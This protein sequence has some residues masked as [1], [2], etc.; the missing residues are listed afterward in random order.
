M[1]RFA[2]IDPVNAGNAQSGSIPRGALRNGSRPLE[3][4][5]LIGDCRTAALVGR[6]GSIDWLCCPR[7][8]S[9]ACFAALLGDSSNG[10]WSIAPCDR[11]ARVSRCYRDGTLVLETGFTA[12]SGRA[13]IIDFMVPHGRGSKIVRLVRGDAG[14]LDM[15]MEL[16]LRFGYGAT[17]PWVSRAPD[18]TLRAVAGPDMMVLRTPVALHGEDL[19]THA[20]FTVRAG[21]TIPF[22]LTYGPSHL[23]EPPT[24]DPDEALRICE[25]FWRDWVD[26]ADA[27]GPYRDIVL[28]SLITLKALTYAPSGGIVAAPTASLPERLGGERNWDYRYCWIRDSTFTLLALMDAGVL[29]EARAWRD[30]LKRAVAGAPAD[31]Q[32]M[33]GLMGER[34]LTEWEA[35]WLRGYAGSRPVRIGNAAHRQ[36]QL[37][38]YGELMDTFEQARKT[39]LTTTDD[40]WAVQVALVKHVAARWRDPDYGMWETRGVPRHF[41]FSKVMAWVTFDRAIQAI[42]LHG[43]SGPIEEW[44]AIRAEIH[45][46]VCRR[47]FDIHANTFRAAYDTT[48]LDASLLLLAQVG[49]LAP[50]DPRFVGTVEAIERH[51]LVDG[52]VL[53]YDTAR[54]PDGLEPGEGVFLACS[55]WLA[56]AYLSLG[57]EA[58]AKAMFERLLGLCNDVG[59][60][61]EEYEPGLRRQVGNFPQ[62]FSHVALINT[63]F[64][65]THA[66][67]PAEQ[68]AK[69]ATPPAK[70]T[71]EAA[72]G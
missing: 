45:R 66:E 55:F 54:E 22:V 26:K 56:D 19:R 21:Q 52:L 12:A 48:T 40:G 14:S 3:E 67:R 8:D 29:E 25:S 11:S 24:I 49:F 38:V 50:D 15:D 34:R 33:Y 32:I 41:T 28:R 10:R 20:T 39:G 4:Y 31:M 6:N 47:G 62:A 36:F 68:R 9:D 59:L 42:E 65:L 64:N 16:V 71:P 17:V 1:R 23:P 61:A 60:L 70:R 7:F 30:W 27:S 43:L 35:D 57:R 53:R 2:L 44:R 72:G 58:D 18:G 5:A 69:A 63:A 51:L 46:D 13:T 37:D